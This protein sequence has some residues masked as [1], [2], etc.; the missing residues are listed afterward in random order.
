MSL[1]LYEKQLLRSISNV[2]A[3]DPNNAKR[4]FEMVRGTTDN[5]AKI[6][7]EIQP[8]VDVVSQYQSMPHSDHYQLYIE[9]LN[10]AIEQLGNN[11]TQVIFKTS[12]EPALKIPAPIPTNLAAG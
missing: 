4:V 5:A 6:I 12:L 11:E 8:I 3:K 1:D 7:T 9:A 2:V 10:S